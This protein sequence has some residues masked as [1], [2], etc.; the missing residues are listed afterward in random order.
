MLGLIPRVAL[1]ASFA[2][3]SIVFLSFFRNTPHFTL[4]SVPQRMFS[5]LFLSLSPLSPLSSLSVSISSRGRGP[6]AFASPGIVPNSQ[7]RRARER[8][9]TTRFS[10]P[11]ASYYHQC[12]S[13][14]SFFFALFITLF[15]FCPGSSLRFV[16]FLFFNFAFTVLPLFAHCLFWPVRLSSFSWNILL[17]CVQIGQA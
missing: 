1:F 8:T 6:Q 12:A 11:W 10:Q 4:M 16:L 9:T 14:R 5:V 13:F 15:F 7:E 17:Q 2:L 3:V